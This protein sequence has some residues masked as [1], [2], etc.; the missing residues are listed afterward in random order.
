M[1]RWLC[2]G[3]LM[4]LLVAPIATQTAGAG[5]AQLEDST[6]SDFDVC[7]A[8]LGNRGPDAGSLVI[9]D[10]ET[11]AGTLVGPTGISGEFSDRGVPALAVRL[12]GELYAMDIG[13]SSNLYRIDAF[14][15][16]ATFVGATGLTSPPAIAFNRKGALFAIDAE[17]DLYTVDRF[18]AAAT[19]VGA[20]GVY[21]KG[22]AFDPITGDLWGSDARGNLYVIDP[23]KGATRLIGNTGMPPSPD[24]C[25]STGGTL[26]AA[27]GGG[28]S[29]NNLITIDMATGVGT[30]VGSIGFAS[31]SG[32][33]LRHDL[34]TPA[35]L[36][37]F[38]ARWSA[39]RVEVMWSLI[40]IV[41]ELSFDIA[42]VSEQTGRISVVNN[43]PVTR[44]GGEFVFE[45]LETE[46]DQTYRYRVA[47]NEDNSLVTSFEVSVRTPGAVLSLAQ[48][49]PNPFN[50]NTTI[51]F[52][53]EREQ[54]VTL[55]VYDVAGRAVATLLDKRMRPGTHAEQWNGR[56]RNGSS[57]AAGV[58]FIRMTAGSRS[59]VRKA[60][61]VK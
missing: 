55:A 13:A 35:T 50:P 37:A 16:N 42:R 22:M 18:T 36:Q 8:T 58:Y 9:V 59:L 57:V 32:M 15:G 44:L 1:Q 54:R 2:G 38:D 41:G 31:L 20:T 4:A 6:L 61:L 51:V 53:V 17:G 11:G 30:V 7:Y 40:D 10:L 24:M 46:P 26:Y 29:V 5:P 49:Y 27:S 56:G 48:N 12:S 45:D 19:F 14:T 47:V 23:K 21:M 33:G 60:V 3:L 25:F 52:S 28:L 34:P 43:A 39:D